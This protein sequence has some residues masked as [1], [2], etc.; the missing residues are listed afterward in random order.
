MTLTS[1]YWAHDTTDEIGETTIGGVL[2][3]AAAETPGR[4]ALVAGMPDPLDRRRWSYAELLADAEKV[5]QALLARFEP[6]EHIAVWAPNIPEWVLLQYGAAL[7]GLVLVTINP[8]Y[9][10]AELEYVLRQSRSAGLFLLPEYRTNS[11]AKSLESVRH[12]LPD[13]RE[14]VLF[15]EWADFMAS[16]GSGGRALPDVSP[17][18]AAA[19][20][21]TSGTTGFPKGA[22]LHHRG[23][24]NDARLIALRMGQGPGDVTINPMPLFH[25]GG[26]VIASLGAS[27]MAG[28]YVPV[29]AFDPGLVLEL[30]ETERGSIMGGVPTMLIAMMEHPD[31][32]TRDFSSL[33]VVLSG[34]APVPAE[35]VRRIESSLGVRFVIVF[36]Q[37]E[38]SAVA[39][40]TRL[41]DT[42]D[43]IAETVGRPLPHIEVKVIDVI[44]GGVVAPG[45]VGE[46][47]IRGF[48]VMNGYYDMPEATSAAIDAD[49]WLHTG[50]LGTM[51]E[52]GYCRIEGRLK[53]MI[54]RGGE[55]IYPREIEAVLY[56]HPAV[57]DVA[58]VGIPDE[59]WGEQVAAFV[60]LT[61]GESVTPAELSAHV[62][63]RLAAYKA[64]RSWV[65][66]DAF[67]MT[68]S[69][70]IQKFVL[71]E[72]YL[73]GELA[74]TIA[75]A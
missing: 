22:L 18:A 52:R 33:R 29:L 55:N 7:A 32:A 68:G 50:D 35:L 59:R 40:Q 39:T 46:L 38:C 51:D 53:D 42:P 74:P 62:R 28:T 66:V 16:S 65:F 19:L 58:V 71:L 25:A 67:P 57:A 70:K 6:G 61:E 45:T 10:P 44:T 69:G 34:G 43:D 21:Y 5:A 24:T 72:R 49:G 14:T 41:D 36:G 73:K 4:T 56:D 3:K 26:C 47:C 2:R 75:G 30:I 15:T 64:P 20:L 8:A 13:L 11:M 17:A 27:G 48:C 63:E 1:S 60:R 54:I 31:F 12:R 37:T 23:M 9:R